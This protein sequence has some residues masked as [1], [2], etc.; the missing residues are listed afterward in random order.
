MPAPGKRRKDM[1]L[2]AMS[3]KIMEN[4][5]EAKKDLHFI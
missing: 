3:A 5:E 1:K 2:C 4:I